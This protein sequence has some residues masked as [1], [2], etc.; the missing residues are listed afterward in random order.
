M[1]V[2]IVSVIGSSEEERELCE[3]ERELREELSRVTGE[4]D[5]LSAQMKTDALRL[6]QLVTSARAQ[7]RH[8]MGTERVQHGHRAGT[9]WA[10][11]GYNMGTERVQHG[12]RAGTGRAD[13]CGE[14][15]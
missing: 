13:W 7:S 6:D 4:R 9:T 11:S 3:E 10:Q 8:N 12:H 1:S 5:I 14:M 15:R 2:G